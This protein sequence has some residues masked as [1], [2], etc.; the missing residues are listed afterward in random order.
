MAA[1]GFD[2]QTNQT[3]LVNTLFNNSSG[4]GLYTT[5]QVQALNVD[6][7]LLT[8]NPADGTFK[9]TLGLQKSSNLQ[10]FTP[11]PMTAPQTL[12]NGDGKLEF[13]FTLPD[14]AAFFRV[15]AN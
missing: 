14:T 8:R 12:I 13:Y 5:S 2:W 3:A 9:L 11:F 1:L 6:G 4:A 10:T 15:Q 7:P